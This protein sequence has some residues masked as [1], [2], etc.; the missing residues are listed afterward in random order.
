MDHLVPEGWEKKF[1]RN[2]AG[3]EFNWKYQ[4]KYDLV[5]T[6]DFKKG[7]VHVFGSHGQLLPEAEFTK[8]PLDKFWTQLPDWARR[9]YIKF[10]MKEI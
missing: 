6:I 9:E 7:I 5:S 3:L 2:V 4:G 1:R 8:I 10:R